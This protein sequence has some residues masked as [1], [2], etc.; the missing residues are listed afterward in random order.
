MTKK[1]TKRE[2]GM[3]DKINELTTDLQRNQ[4]DFENFRRRSEEEQAQSVSFGK[5]SAVIDFL[6]VLDNLE[7]A[8]THVPDDLKDHQY[9]KG[10]SGVIK[11]THEVFDKFGLERIKTVGEQFDAEIMSAVQMD[12][13]EGDTEVVIEELQSGYMLSG[14]VVRHAMVKVGRK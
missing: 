14:A 7:R 6:P 13:S 10:M 4:A 1:L 9:M 2:Q 11:Q 5:R 3:L 8:I 12:D